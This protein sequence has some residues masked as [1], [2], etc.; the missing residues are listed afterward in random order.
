MIKYVRTQSWRSAV[1]L[2]MTNDD[3]E[4]NKLVKEGKARGKIGKK[5]LSVRMV[6][7]LFGLKLK[8]KDNDIADSILIGLSAYKKV[9]YGDP[10]E[11]KTKK[12][13][14]T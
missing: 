3:K 12:S 2:K 9:K 1:D 4:H 11:V 6:N 7:S 10:Y 14:R 8:L 5:H 13:S